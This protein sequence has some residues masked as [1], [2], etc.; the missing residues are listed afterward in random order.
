[1]KKKLFSILLALVLALSLSPVT[2]VVAADGS[3]ITGAVTLGTTYTGISE[4]ITDET[5]QC[6]SHSAKLVWPAPYRDEEDNYIVPR[7]FADIAIPSGLEVSGVSSWSYWV[8]APEDYA[9]NLIFYVDTTGDGSSDTTISAWPKNDP[10]LADVWTQIDQTTIGGY[11]GIYLVWGS[12][13]WPSFKSSWDAVQSAY[14]SAV[15][16]KVKIGKG[17]IGTNQEITAY[18]DDFT[19]ND[20]TYVFEPPTKADILS[21]VP[22]KGLDKAPGLQKPFNPNSQAEDN[23]GKK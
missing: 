9:P 22:G 2:A 1:M 8:K 3:S 6:D 13:P 11:K 21:D 4:W 15:I 17:V 19:L 18:V 14:G 16:M 5:A 7:A 12:N 20:T 23:A 10:P